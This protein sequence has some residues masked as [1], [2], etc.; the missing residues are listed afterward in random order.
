MAQKRN[1]FVDD[2]VKAANMALNIVPE[3]AQT[4]LLSNLI[5]LQNFFFAKIC[6]P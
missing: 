5:S 3:Y 2:S 4:C 1:I 6:F